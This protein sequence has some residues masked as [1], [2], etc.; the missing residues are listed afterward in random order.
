MDTPSRRRKHQVHRAHD[1]FGSPAQFGELI[2]AIES[3]RRV[4]VAPLADDGA[5]DR[6]QRLLPRI[7]ELLN[8]RVPF[9]H[10][11]S[12]VE[13]A[14]GLE[15]GAKVDRDSLATQELQS[16][17]RVVEQRSACF[18]T[19]ECQLLD[20]RHTK[21]KAQW[22]WRF[23]LVGAGLC[24]EW[25]KVRRHLQYRV[26]IRRI[27]GKN[28]DTIQRAAG[29]DHTA[30]GEQATCRLDPDQIIEGGGHPPRARRV[31]AQ[32][33]TDLTERHRHG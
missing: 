20:T 28:G 25:V 12:L 15:E 8:G 13:Q 33:E 26:R 29:G 30:R 16:L 1:L 6:K 14:R 3:L 18:I 27:E 22:E 21:A 17:D 4:E 5:N 2:E 31:G 24:I 19:K 11:G 32:R 23:K 7:E 9:G 10:P